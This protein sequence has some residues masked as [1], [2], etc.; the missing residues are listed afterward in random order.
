V[1]KF[2]RPR[3]APPKRPW[4]SGKIK[5]WSRK[6]QWAS[7]AKAWDDHCD[8]EALT[9]HLK[10][11]RDM[12]QRHAEAAISLQRRALEALERLDP[13]SLKPGDV[14]RFLAEAVEM[15]RTA[16]GAMDQAYYE[17]EL[18]NRAK[19]QFW[20]LNNKRERQLEED[21]EARLRAAVRPEDWRIL[22][23]L[24][25]TGL[26]R[27]ELLGLQRNEVHLKRKTCRIPDTKGGKARM[28]PLNSRA[29]ELLREQLESHASE[30]VFPS[31]TGDSPMNGD[32]FYHRVWRPS[33]KQAGIKNLRIHDLRHTF[34]SRLVGLGVGLRAV[35]LLAGH[36]SF[37]TTE[38]Y[39][40][41][42]PGQLSDAVELLAR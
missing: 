35:Q 7:R 39:A 32:N 31:K 19:V 21:E 27:G 17:Q 6:W 13:S 16:R 5:E 38:R 36:K 4:A 3:K 22:E 28:V 10:Q 8:R 26:R 23:L 41:L 40:H 29:V 9:A 1:H 33:L 30:W 14:V 11:I 2:I 34:C 18:L 25:H 20:K 42:T 12:R 37:A 15:E 24:V